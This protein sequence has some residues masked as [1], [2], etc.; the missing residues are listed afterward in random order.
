MVSDANVENDRQQLLSTS[1]ADVFN[2]SI[3]LS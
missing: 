1:F 3:N 2:G